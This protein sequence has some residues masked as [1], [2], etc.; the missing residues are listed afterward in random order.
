V[1]LSRARAGAV[2]AAVAFGCVALPAAG[3]PGAD[4]PAGASAEAPAADAADPDPAAAP[5]E[6]PAEDGATGYLAFGLLFQENTLSEPFGDADSG[7]AGMFARGLA[8]SEPVSPA[9]DI[10]LSGL[11][12]GVGREYPD[13]EKVGDTLVEID[14]GMRINRLFLLSAG[15][16]TLISAYKTSDV[17]FAYNVVMLGAAFLKTHENGYI[18][19]QA[20]AGSGKH[21]NDYNDDVEGVSY[22]GLRAVAHFGFGT[23]QHLQLGVG[24]DRYEVEEL[25]QTEEFLR[26]ELGLG[27]GI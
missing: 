17:T 13:G 9:I 2:V 26:A 4:V 23:S 6:L 1:R 15:Y 14:G 10:V 19:V 3:Q 5:P 22:G 16:S 25:D 12:G 18:L 8:H 27:F 21:T 24:I 20:R 11:V 7:G